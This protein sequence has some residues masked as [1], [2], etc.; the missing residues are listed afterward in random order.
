M[1]YLL[2]FLVLA[3][4]WWSWSKGGA[5]RREGDAGSAPRPA[6]RMLTCRQCGVHFPE[7]DGVTGAKGVYCCAAHRA[8]AD[9]EM[10]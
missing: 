8:Q 10:S 6:E 5:R 7:S 9:G 3:V 1:K 2:L 4:L